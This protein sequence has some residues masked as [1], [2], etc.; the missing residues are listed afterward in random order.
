V[1]DPY[2]DREQTKAKH[3]LLKSY[4]QALAFKILRFS[5]LTYVDGF[6]GPWKTR[7]ENFSD[8][9]FMIAL[10]AL[11]DAQQ[12]I[13]EET[14]ERRRVRCFFSES[15][16]IAF[17][18][19]EAAVAPYNR[20]QDRFEIKTFRGRFENAVAEIQDFVGQSFALILI[21]PTGWV[22]YPFE[23]IKSL[24]APRLC[25]VLINFM[26]SFVS[27][28]IE[29]EDATIIESLNPILGGPGWR[30]RLDPKLPRGEALL[31]LFRETLKAAGNFEYVVATK[32]DR[33]TQDRPHFF[34]AYGTKV[35][36]GLK[37]FRDIEY[38][39]LRA[40]AGNR[41]SAKERKR[42]AQS[43]S[44]DLF[45]HHEADVREASVDEQVKADMGRAAP[46]VLEM[47]GRAGSL[48]FAQV[49]AK[50]MEN[51]MLRET[52]VKDILLELARDNKIENTWGR[53]N[54][55]PGGNDIIRFKTAPEAS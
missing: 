20:P 8:S 28:F 16:P 46:L 9:S 21:D 35:Y 51:F 14:G 43:G 6:S 34:M 30:A 48:S 31:K 50:L 3:F 45:A 29:T 18:K 2:E 25:E 52:N 54:R 13:F 37:T 47:V 10:T 36:A 40:H 22:G 33:A 44:R 17:A 11:R 23:K 4:L 38:K 49:A 41:A 7:T 15:D 53:G 27:R 1:S 55:K 42:G 39:A 26:Y 19:L 32:I 12:R 24:F 5:D